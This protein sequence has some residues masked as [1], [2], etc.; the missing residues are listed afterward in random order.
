MCLSVDA[1]DIMDGQVR[2]PYLYE[3]E[4]NKSIPCARS[5]NL[6]YNF[7]KF[8]CLSFYEDA[9]SGLN[10]FTTL[11][12]MTE[13]STGVTLKCDKGKNSMTVHGIVV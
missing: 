7:P 1:L 5:E 2:V 8:I 12:K 9:L 4:K 10:N 11:E 6:L 3:T 13:R